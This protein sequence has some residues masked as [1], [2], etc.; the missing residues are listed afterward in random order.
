M[1]RKILFILVISLVVTHPLKA[2]KE[3][4]TNSSTFI[5]ADDTEL[6]SLVAARMEDKYGIKPHLLQTISSVETGLWDYNK[7]KFVSW[8]WTI[9]V[10]G[11]GKHFKTKTEAVAEVRRLQEKG[12]KNIDV[13]CMQIS[14][15]YHANAFDSVED[16]FEPEKNVEYS[17][18]FLKKLYAKRKDWQKAAMDYHSK[19]PSKGLKYKKKLVKRFEKIKLA[20][21]ETSQNYT[22]F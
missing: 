3:Y 7:E 4:K 5:K 8:P 22:L 20:F 15:K 9:N 2:Q 14:L 18:K 6:C 1:L 16:A 10:N 13:G 19:I 21:L 17:A 11:K 12:V